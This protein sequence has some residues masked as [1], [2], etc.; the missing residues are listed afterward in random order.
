[1]F[2]ATRIAMVLVLALAVVRPAAAEGLESDIAVVNLE[3]VMRT[4][5]AAKSVQEQIDKFRKEYQDEISD[6]EEKLHKRDKELADQ[7][8]ILAPEAF[9]QER[10]SF[11]KEVAGVQRDV[12]IKRAQLDR[13]YA[14]AASKIQLT[15]SKIV[16]DYAKEK[17]FKLILPSSQILYGEEALNISEEV[18]KRLDNE[19][20]KVEVKIEPLPDPK[21][22]DSE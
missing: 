6:E 18:L 17:G 3:G 13:A 12:Q 15:I 21:S 4:A 16:G 8:S 11:Q 22:K 10:R 19:L 7:R 5:K 20:P 2:L 14:K 9:E 1:M